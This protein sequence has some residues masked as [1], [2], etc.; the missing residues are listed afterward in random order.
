M[1]WTPGT[2]CVFDGLEWVKERCTEWLGER[3]SEKKVGEV[4]REDEKTRAHEEHGADG[5]HESHGSES[6]RQPRPVPAVQADMPPGI[7][8]V[9]AEPIQDRKSAFVGR[10]CRISDP[11]QASAVFL[12][13]C[14]SVLT[15]SPGPG[16]SGASH[17][18]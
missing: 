3:M 16:D 8:I 9:E 6:A 14:R 11:S 13:A 17:V 18:R 15:V 10:A 2:E 12:A 5:E 1:E 4:L 7:T